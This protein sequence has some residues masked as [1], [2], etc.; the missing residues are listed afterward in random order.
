[1]YFPYLYGR[2]FELLALR[3]AS[4]EFPLAGTIAP[5]I[6]PVRENPAD[7]KRCLQALGAKR[8][9]AV[10]ISNPHQG[11]FRD[12]SPAALLRA[13]AEDFALH[14]SLL[15]G[16]LCD[17]RVRVQDVAAFLGRYP[18]RDVAL[19][20]SGFQVTAEELRGVAAEHRIRFHIS[21][22]DQM[23]ANLRAVLPR[24]KAVDIRDRFNLQPRNADY[25]GA[26]FFTDAHLLFRE[27]AVGFGDY[28]V[29]G[30]AF[31][32]GGGPAHAVAIHAVFRQAET[33]QVWVEHF[34]SDDVDPDVG[35]VEEKFHQAAA[36]LVRA[37][38]RR[39]AE[40]G[41]N[42]ALEAHATD[43]RTNHFPG[44]GENKRREIHHHLA[45]NHGILH[46]AR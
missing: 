22:R 2:R 46:V 3:S 18:D 41:E 30:S 20:Y 7:L 25:A 34:V 35:S 13:L 38:H 19:L 32:V 23:A 28:S 8:V 11:D 27:N 29:I 6:E 45:I 37:V 16:L 10:V 40:F 26:E 33:G 14:R 9:R 15:P 44:L 42:S 5:V 31:H 21:V 39:R 36:K 43:V 24:G 4:T 1:M 17:H 12:H